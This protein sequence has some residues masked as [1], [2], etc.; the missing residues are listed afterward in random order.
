MLKDRFLTK[1][2]R[3]NDNGGAV[4]DRD[5]ELEEGKRQRQDRDKV[6]NGRS[7]G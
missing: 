6:E 5:V 7:R 1:A 2:F 4:G 3:E